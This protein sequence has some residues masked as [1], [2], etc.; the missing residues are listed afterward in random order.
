M[1]LE[2]NDIGG[3]P[4][5]P[6]LVAMR[7]AVAP[8]GEARSDFAIF[9]DLAAALGVGERFAEGRDEMG[10]WGGCAISMRA[11]VVG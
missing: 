4:N 9:A 11:G 7:Q 6:C 2:R 1:T 5:D 3:S 10:C 8:F